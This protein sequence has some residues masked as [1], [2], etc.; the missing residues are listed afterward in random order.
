MKSK[1]GA[2]YARHISNCERILEKIDSMRFKRADLYNMVCAYCGRE[3]NV[4]SRNESHEFECKS[5]EELPNSV[6]SN[7]IGRLW[8]F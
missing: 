1:A 5:C 6:T 8:T 3:D 7:E 4:M 2:I